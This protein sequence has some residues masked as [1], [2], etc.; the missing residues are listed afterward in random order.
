MASQNDATPARPNHGRWLKRNRKEF[1]M[2][3]ISTP[4]AIAAA[5]ILAAI[6][7]PS[8]ASNGFTPAN[9]ESGGA[10]HAMPGG[11]TRAE[12]LAELQKAREDGSLAKVSSEASYAPEI[13][14]A[15]RRP[16]HVAALPSVKLGAGQIQFEA[17]AAGAG[18]TRA[19]VLEELRRAREDGS[20]RRMNTNRGY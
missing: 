9:T 6:S 3:R 18:R 17:P 10:Y 20:L 4:I 15:A 19:E 2:S 12:V 16:A 14:A 1:I 8:M 11:K 13:E 7:I 5:A